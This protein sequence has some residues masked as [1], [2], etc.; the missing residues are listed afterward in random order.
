MPA[1]LGA[2]LNLEV[3]LIV[4]LGERRMRV[5]EVMGLAA[6]AI[7]ELP[8]KADEELSL[9]VNNKAIGTGL[10][11]KVGENFGLRITYVGDLKERIDAM[12]AG[13]AAGVQPA[14][15]GAPPEAPAVSGQ[16]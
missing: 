5:S 7:I 14:F 11:V 6:G 16:A 2:I 3:P 13:P 15:A 8:K 1:D 10:A 4:V 9:L 12:G